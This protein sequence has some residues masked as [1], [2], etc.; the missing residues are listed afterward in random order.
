MYSKA[1]SVKFS[2]ILTPDTDLLENVCGENE[3]D[4]IHFKH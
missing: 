3:R 1:F 4:R 2:K